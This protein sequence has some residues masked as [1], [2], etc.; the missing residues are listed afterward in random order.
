MLK[1]Y[2]Q[3]MRFHK[4]I[5][6]FLLLWPTM[7]ALW[8][9]AHGFPEIKNLI[10]FIGGVILMRA[11]GC[12]INDVAD[13]KLDLHVKRTQFRLLTTGEISV[14]HAMIL[15]CG[16]CLFAFILVL[17]TNLFTILLS[18]VALF[19]ASLYPFMKRYTHFPQVVLG[20]AFAF[21]VPMAFAAE[22]NHLNVTCLL[23]F[24]AT[25][26]WTIAYDTEYAMTDRDDDLKIGIKSTAIFFGKYDRWTIGL[27]QSIF[28]SLLMIVG[29]REHFSLIYF[30]SLFFAGLLFLYQHFL[31]RKREPEKCFQAFLNNHWVG[32]LI[33]L[34]IILSF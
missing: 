12:V 30:T 20:I 22:K 31:M 5:G 24:L 25:I 6:I 26:I 15:F 14:R 33:F 9:S 19:V 2:F 29:A 28:L 10:I 3:L 21:S 34:G 23:L 11:A 7:W 32:L 1:K 4:P 13:R 18:I 8:I 17:F 27:L 16:L